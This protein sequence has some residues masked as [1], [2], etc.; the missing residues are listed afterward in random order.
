M[1]EV[2]FGAIRCGPVVPV[3]MPRC[4]GCRNLLGLIGFRTRNDGT[5]DSLAAGSSPAVLDA[6]KDGCYGQRASHCIFDSII[7]TVSLRSE[8]ASISILTSPKG[9]SLHGHIEEWPTVPLGSFR[10]YRITAQSNSLPQFSTPLSILTFSITTSAGVDLPKKPSGLICLVRSIV[11]VEHS[12]R[13][14]WQ[15]VE[16]NSH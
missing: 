11:V 13:R 1:P 5:V 9:A 12:L 7:T 6:V 16:G 10:S 14:V 8:S 2:Y 3:T 15:Y 4:F